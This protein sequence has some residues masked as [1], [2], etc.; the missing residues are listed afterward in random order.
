MLVPPFAMRTVPVT[1]DAVP[2]MLSVEVAMAVTFPV[3]PV[4]LPSKVFA[5]MVGSC[6]SVRAFAA[7]PRVTAV[8]P[9]CAPSVPLVTEMPVPTE[10][11]EV[12]TD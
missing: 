4:V 11:E 10:M 9:T 3:A 12:A 8:P 6:E 1:F 5:A 2:P 7:M